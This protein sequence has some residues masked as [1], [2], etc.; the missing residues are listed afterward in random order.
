MEM[1]DV[2]HVEVCQKVDSA[3]SRKDVE[4]VVRT[5]LT[6]FEE[7]TLNVSMP[8][9]SFSKDIIKS[10][11]ESIVC[12]SN[13][14]ERSHMKI[15]SSTLRVYVYRL[16]QENAATETI[17]TDS[18][19]MSASA[20]WILPSKDFHGLW[21][22][23]IYESDVKEHLL[24]FVETTMLFSDR[25]VDPNI[26][27]WNKVILLHGPPG[28]GK[29]SLCKALAHKAAIRL[30]YHYSHGELV[31]INSHSLF[32]KWFS[33]SGKLVMKLFDDVKALLED[34]KAL[35]CIL[36]DEVES[37]AHVRKS[38]TNGT[39]P[40]DSIRVVNALLTQLDQ[41]KKYPNVLILTTSNVT[42]AIDVAF[43]DRADIRQFIGFP[44][45][46]AIYKI[47]S[48]CIKELM[49]TGFVE[50]EILSEMSYLKKLGYEENVETRHSLMLLELSKQSVGMSGRALRKIP[51]L[52]HALYTQTTKC[53][54]PRF[55][56]AMH[57]AIEKQKEEEIA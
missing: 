45:E 4:E 25:N 22:S 3:L 38:C 5:E 42:E 26:I 32:S 43:I 20:H 8:G 56:R 33:E 54:V 17:R 16:T 2:L 14:T 9:E 1:H 53:T 31:E 13:S 23:L 6:S 28:T 7:V 24:H 48:S 46:Q 55:L 40:S 29:T 18:D 50:S 12:S 11:V 44:S 39:E 34:P 52:A 21:E 35:V 41:I 49:R 15:Q 36:I 10:H 47:Y 51:F 19:D 37:L 57:L 30:A 27:S